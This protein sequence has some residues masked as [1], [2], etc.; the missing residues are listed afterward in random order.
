MNLSDL[1]PHS[2]PQNCK[3]AQTSL[4]VM[5]ESSQSVWW[6]LVCWRELLVWWTTK[7]TV[8]KGRKLTLACIQTFANQFL[9]NLGPW[10]IL[11]MS[12]VCCQFKWPW[13]SFS[14]TR[15]WAPILHVCADMELEPGSCLFY[16]GQSLFTRENPRWYYKYIHL[17]WLCFPKL[18]KRFLWTWFDD[19]HL[20][21]LPLGISFRAFDLHARSQ[22]YNSDHRHTS[23]GCQHK[24]RETISCEW[25]SK[26]KDNWNVSLCSDV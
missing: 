17:F 2:R 24:W 10:W 4:P 12:P 8:L 22:G 21:T 3:K 15:F 23:C 18:M 25:L 14:V 20:W 16:W 1:Y 6:K 19:R 9:F 5:A 13:L 11:L 26:K 7:M